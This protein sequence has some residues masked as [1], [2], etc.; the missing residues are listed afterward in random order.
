[1]G[2]ETPSRVEIVESWLMAAEAGRSHAVRMVKKQNSGILYR[3][4]V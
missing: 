2:I 4:Q 3:V 1:L